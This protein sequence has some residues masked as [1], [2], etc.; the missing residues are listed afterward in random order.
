MAI[1][2]SSGVKA[3]A[4][5]RLIAIDGRSWAN[6]TVGEEEEKA[7]QREGNGLRFLHRVN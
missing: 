4:A 3:E 5:T 2:D 7:V 6:P 1:G